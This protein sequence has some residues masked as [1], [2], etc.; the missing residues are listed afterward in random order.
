MNL[1]EIYKR[2]EKI[3]I[4]KLTASPKCHDWEHTQRVM[5]NAELLMIWEKNVN[6][7]VV[8]FAVL[9]HDIARADEIVANGV[10]CHAL[11]GSELSNEILKNEG[12]D[13]ILRGK[14]V[15]C[16]KKHRFRSSDKPVTLE[17]KIVYDADKLDSVGAVG[18]ARAFLFA[19]RSGA[20]VHN[21][22]QEAINSMSYSEDDTAYREYLV[23][24]RHI[25]QKMM[26]ETA[27][28]IALVRVRYMS[29]FF[30]RL[31]NEVYNHVLCEFH[32]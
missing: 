16:V 6:K 31:D 11:I 24:L 19:G 32:E 23:K 20:K 27:R 9:L 10:G 17:E 2:L 30:E 13:D 5:N 22:E 4:E 15:N 26:T 25:P 28:K 8:R 18:L 29:E 12:I 21:T 14:I 3:V 7:N 1:D